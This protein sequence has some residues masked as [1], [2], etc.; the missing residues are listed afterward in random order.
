MKQLAAVVNKSSVTNIA[1]RY[2]AWPW[3]NWKEFL[4]DHLKAL[5]GIRKYQ[6]FKFCVDEP[7]LVTVRAAGDATAMTVCILKD[8]AFRFRDAGRPGIVH[9]AGLN[10]ARQ[11]YLHKTVRPYV[12]PAFQDRLCP[13]PQED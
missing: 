1:V 8:S 11:H 5:A 10:K 3:R 9:A 13:E 4:G 6:Y 12:R 7:G 2:P